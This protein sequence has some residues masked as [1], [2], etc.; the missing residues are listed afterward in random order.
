MSHA[1]NL[2]RHSKQNVAPLA[3][4]ILHFISKL[5]NRFFLRK[6]KPCLHAC[7]DTTCNF[8]A[9]IISKSFERKHEDEARPALK[10]VYIFFLKKKMFLKQ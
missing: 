1:P 4:T 2:F 5:Q 8:V 3:T 9:G 6:K 7:S 10:E